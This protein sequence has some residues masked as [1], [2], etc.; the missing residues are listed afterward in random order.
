[1]IEVVAA[2]SLSFSFSIL[3]ISLAAVSWTAALSQLAAETVRWIAKL[4]GWGLW[5]DH[6]SYLLLCG[7]KH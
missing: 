5:W 6:V 2:W 7:L 1:M 4:I 3:L